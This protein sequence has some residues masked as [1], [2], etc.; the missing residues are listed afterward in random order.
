MDWRVWR[1]IVH[2]V[3]AQSKTQLK[4]LSTRHRREK[5]EERRFRE[6]MA[7]TSQK[8]F[9]KLICTFKS[10]NKIHAVLERTTPRHIV[11]KLVKTKNLES[12]ES[13]IIYHIEG[14]LNKIISRFLIRNFGVQKLV[15]WCF[16]LSVERKL[17]LLFNIQPNYHVKKEETNTFPDK[18]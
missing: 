10:L 7:Q 12:S 16:Q 5:R 1:A 15:R 17:N 14:T 8:W 11:D 13:K 18:W 2:R 6:T 9:K 4:W 3:I